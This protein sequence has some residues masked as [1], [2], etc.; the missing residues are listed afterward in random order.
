MKKVGVLFIAFFLVLVVVSAQVN[1]TANETIEQKAYSCLENKV[2]N[3]CTTLNFEE[4]VFSLLAV[5]Y[6]SNIQT[7]CKSSLKS[8][9]L[10]N[11]CWP[12][13]GC[14]IKDTSLALLALNNINEDTNK[15]ENWMDGKK[16]IPIELE[17]YLQIDSNVK[18]QC[19]ITAGAETKT[20]TINEDKKISGSPGSCFSLAYDNYWLRVQ[21]T[22]IAKNISVKC[23]QDFIS[24]ISY[25]KTG[26]NIWNIQSQTKSESASGT[27]QHQI[28]VHCLSTGLKCNYEDNL[29]AVLAL[30]QAGEDV[31]DLMP[32]IITL[33][34]NNPKLFPDSFIYISSASDES[35]QNIILSQKTQG[36]WDFFDKGKNYDTALAMLALSESEAESQAKEWLADIQGNDGCWNNGNIRDTGFLLWA[37]W[38]K[39]PSIISGGSS[40]DSCEPSYYCVSQGECI[41]EDRQENYDCPG[42]EVCCSVKPA[43]ETCQDRNGKICS[44][45]ET[46]SVATI[47][48]GNEEC[49]LGECEAGVPECENQG[50]YCRSECFNTEEIISYYDCPTGKMCCKKTQSSGSLLWLWILIILIILVVLGII[51]RNQL[52][53]WFFKIKSKFK[54]SKPS[55]AKPPYLPY[56][57]TPA[58]YRRMMPMSPG[59]KAR[60][61]MRAM[62]ASARPKTK[63]EKEL[64]ETMSK[65][66]SMSS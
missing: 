7:E 25:K 29:W 63:T 2:R 47:T 32:Y 22:C 56:S 49:C 38:P 61:G 19:D 4:Q 42:L 64:E 60:P 31:S 13:S 66:K 40:S 12:S 43:E 50:N 48:L 62:P 55:S 8:K 1:Q 16:I 41:I 18:T 6:N 45:G 39:T 57:G 27:T 33:A 24:T 52:R 53:I 58:G 30:K 51:F 59:M 5:S 34:E 65:L 36:Y 37:G 26:S 54:G 11:E 21:N 44:A 15:I 14:K 10:N 35:L 46:C 20:I 17:W 23:D 9:A 28:N 3:K